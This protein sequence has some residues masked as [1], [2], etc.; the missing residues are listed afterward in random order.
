MSRVS[1]CLL[2]NLKQNALVIIPSMRQLRSG[3]NLLIRELK[4]HFLFLTRAQIQRILARP[5]SSTKR[6]IAELV[7]NK[8]LARRYRSDTFGHFQTPLYYLGELGWRRAGNPSDGYRRYR[9]RVEER[10][11]WHTDHL[12]AVYDVLLKFVLKSHVRRIIGGED[13]FWRE[14][15][16]FGSIPDAWIQF[17]GGE[18][19]IEVDRE[20]ERPSIVARKIQNYVN[21]KRTD[22]YR[23]QFP[24]CVFRVLFVTQ[25]EERI[26]ALERLSDSD[27]IWFITMRQFLGEKLGDEHWFAVN[28]FYALPLDAK[29]KM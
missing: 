18:A 14:G 24:G 4:D 6:E 28:G 21:F 10:A 9:S 29:E 1:G 11:E 2:L 22:D 8:Y 23:S 5:T 7:A 20:T 12:L 19:F 26:E 3:H 16:E 17:E 13:S 25:S 15:F 27:D